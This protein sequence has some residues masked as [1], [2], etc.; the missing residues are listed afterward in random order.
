MATKL[1]DFASAIKIVHTLGPYSPED[2]EL[3]SPAIDLIEGDG[4]AFAIIAV[5]TVGNGATLGASLQ[6]S[7]D[8]SAWEDI[9][10]AATDSGPVESNAI[11][12]LTFTRKHRYVRI[13]VDVFN[14]DNPMPIV[15]LIGQGRKQI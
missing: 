12:A 4:P 9:P 6:T 8:A 13:I 1:N 3:T 7:A 5:G 14:S 15:V 10:G 11:R 2:T